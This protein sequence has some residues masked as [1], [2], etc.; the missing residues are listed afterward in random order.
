[1][2]KLY[3]LFI[4]C[5]LGN[6]NSISANTTLLFEKYGSTFTDKAAD[7]AFRCGSLCLGCA[8]SCLAVDQ[9]CTQSFNK[10][11]SAKPWNFSELA[12]LST[13]KEPSYYETSRFTKK[14]E[15]YKDQES[16]TGNTKED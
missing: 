2:K 16:P 4:L 8:F 10:L 1:M 9:Y 6:I 12:I 5:L 3:I 13:F 7:A 14:P 15:S 11:C